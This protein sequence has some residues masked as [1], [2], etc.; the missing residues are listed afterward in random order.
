LRLHTNPY[1]RSSHR[2]AV[3]SRLSRLVHSRLRVAD[4]PVRIHLDLDSDDTTGAASP[5]APELG[6]DLSIEITAGERWGDPYFFAT[7]YDATGTAEAL[8]FERVEPLHMPN[9]AGETFELRVRR[10]AHPA[11]LEGGPARGVTIMEG[12]RWARSGRDWSLT[13]AAEAYDFEAP[14]G[15]ELAPVEAELP[16]KA[17]GSIRVVAHNVLWTGPESNP[18]PFARMY[19]AL[20]PDIYLI[21]EWGQGEWSPGYER[22]LER[23]FELY[24]DGTR[25]WT[26]IRSEAWGV[27]LV[28]HHPVIG[29]TPLDLRAETITRWSFPVRYVGGVILTPEGP[30]AAA[31]IHLKAGGALETPEDQRRFDEML[32]IRRELAEMTADAAQAARGATPITILGGD[33]NHNGHPLVVETGLKGLDAD[34]TPLELAYTPVLGTNARYSFGGPAY[35]H[36]RSFL[37]Y[38]AYSDAVAELTAVFVLDTEILSDSSL[39]GMGL[40]RSDSSAADHLP[41]VVDLDPID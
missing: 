33:Y 27:A 2:A 37:D 36:R 38:I 3:S 19:R 21:Q 23:W 4:R 20:D 34:G 17:P 18:E 41:V 1:L 5:E 11:L 26:A 30:V 9:S 10:D 35:G 14:A 28:T 25:D 24:V 12:A 15:R 40:E 13:D 16:A 32:V 22:S 6:V 7:V 8:P 29:R 31:S 39:A